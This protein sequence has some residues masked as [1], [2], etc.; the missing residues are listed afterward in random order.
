LTALVERLLDIL[1]T[2]IF[3]AITS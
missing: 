3:F 2:T 1:T